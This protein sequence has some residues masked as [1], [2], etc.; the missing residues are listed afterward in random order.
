MTSVF[1]QNIAVDEAWRPFLTRSNVNLLKK[2]ESQI[3][4]RPYTPQ[5]DKVLRFFEFPLDSVRVIILGQDPYPQA[6][7]ATGRAFEVGT[8][9]SWDQ[10]FRNISLKNILRAVYKAYAGEVIPYNE[11]KK[12]F[13]S[14]F[15][16][17]PPGELFTHWEQQGVL[18]LNTSFTCEPGN[19]GSHRSLWNSFTVR[20]LSFISERAGSAVWFLWGRHATEVSG[21]LKL[22]KF[23]TLMHPMMCYDNPSRRNDFLYGDV[24][25]FER[26][27]DII[28]W[29]GFSKPGQANDTMGH[30]S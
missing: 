3:L 7:A 28:D 22:N 26:F 2:I 15:P 5:A 13:S 17:L 25:C 18:L 4:N 11:L 8:L 12:K 30:Q 27:A 6:G 10:S 23:I 20:L 16:V 21:H 29:T 1:L 19:P 14:G 9:T 24:N